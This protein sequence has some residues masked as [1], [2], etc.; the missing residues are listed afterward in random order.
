MVKSFTHG[1]GFLCLALF[2]NGYAYDLPPVNLGGT[3]YLDAAPGPSGLYWIQ[4]VQHY[5][6]DKFKDG[7]GN[8]IAFPSPEIDVTVSLTQL[9]YGSDYELLGG[10]LGFQAFFPVVSP[11]AS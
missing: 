3:S 4:Y 11:H 1:L 9:L 2:Q 5:H 8:T 10:K 6:S 7:N